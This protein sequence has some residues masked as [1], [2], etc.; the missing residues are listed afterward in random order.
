MGRFIAENLKILKL[1]I[2][3]F[4]L[5]LSQSCQKMMK[6]PNT[7]YGTH[8]NPFTLLI[9]SSVHQYWSSWYNF[10]TFIWKS[11]AFG[12]IAPSSVAFYW[13]LEQFKITKGP[14]PSSLPLPIAYFK[15]VDNPT[16]ATLTEQLF[17][18]KLFWSPDKLSI[19]FAWNVFNLDVK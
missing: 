14:K 11:K 15:M 16:F 2:A 17:I 6:R 5:K 9:F 19:S 8:M 4:L 13:Q 18:L 12:A 1:V 7:E 3:K 10:L